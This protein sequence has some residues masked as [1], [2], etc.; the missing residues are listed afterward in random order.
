MR[1]F[2]HALVDNHE[3]R[4]EAIR[5]MVRQYVRAQSSDPRAPTAETIEN[6]D[7]EIESPE[8]RPVPS[9][10][11]EGVDAAVAKIDREFGLEGNA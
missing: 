2:D 5:E 8:Y 3:T 6:A 7:V 4:S 1:A 10:A 9:S 11:W